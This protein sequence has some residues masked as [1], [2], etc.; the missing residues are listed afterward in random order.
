MQQDLVEHTA[1]DVAVA[2]V[3]GGHLHRLGDRAAER[4]RGTGE[5]FQN[6]APDVRGIG[7]RRGHIRAVGAHDLA[8]EGFLLIADLDHEHLQV[9]AEIRA[10]HGKRRAPLT[11]AGLRG[12]ALEPLLLRVIRLRDG[13]VQLM[14][15][16]RVVALEFVVDLRGGSERLLEAVGAHQRSRTVHLVEIADLLRDLDERGGIVKLLLNELLAEDAAHLL[17]S[18]GLAGPGIE[19]GGGLDLHIRTDVVPGLGDLFFRQIN[20]VR[21][22]V[23]VHDAFSFQ[24]RKQNKKT[25][26]ALLLGQVLITCGATRLGASAPA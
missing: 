12:H 15:A 23:L 21:D 4:S 22:L 7:G 2:G 6:A 14:A 5:F 11:G 19:Q 25:A 17:R 3:R 9:E 16:A 13:G 1:E 26:P 10:G 20:F 18:Q 8:A 24:N